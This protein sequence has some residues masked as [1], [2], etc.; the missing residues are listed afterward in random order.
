MAQDGQAALRG[1][2]RPVE[3]AMI[4]TDL[5]FPIASLP[6]REGQSFSKGDIL[7]AFDCADLE[8]QVKSAEAVLRAETI[9][10]DNNA[11]LARSKAVGRFEVA[12]SQ[13]KTDQAAAEVE[14]FKSK[15]SRCV[16]RAPYDG[17]I[18]AIRAHQHEIPEPNQPLMQIVSQSDL[19]IEVLLPSTWLRW[20]KIGSPFSI[21]I[22]ELGKTRQAEV[23]RIA[24]I[25]DPVSQTVKVIGRFTDDLDGILP[26]MSGQARFKDMP[27]DSFDE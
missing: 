21:D 12:L 24:A 25:V 18:A 6:F 26:G 5:S 9:T 20:L 8:A 15:M 1:I 7:A 3:E 4:G 17:R 22:D 19:E 11:R 10:R 2:V 14:A 16:I 13:A 23:G 27:A